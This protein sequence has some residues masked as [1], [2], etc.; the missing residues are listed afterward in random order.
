MS[1]QITLEWIEGQNFVASDEGGNQVQVGGREAATPAMRPM[2]LVLAA[3]AGC[4]ATGVRNILAKQRQPFSALR[5]EVRGERKPEPP[6]TFVSIHVR[7]RVRGAGLDRRRV[8][9]AVRLTEEKYCSVYALLRQ[10]VPI[11]TELFVEEEDA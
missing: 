10:A 9:Q 11:E 3:L 7:V 5:F 1:T 8:E 6:T 4:A 2:H